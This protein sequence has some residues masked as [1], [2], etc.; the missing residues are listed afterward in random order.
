VQQSF[1]GSVVKSVSAVEQQ[2]CSGFSG[3]ILRK[4]PGVMSTTLAS[5]P[6]CRFGKATAERGIIAT[7]RPG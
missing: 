2:S 6:I 7:H 5:M 4:S 3:Y 1:P